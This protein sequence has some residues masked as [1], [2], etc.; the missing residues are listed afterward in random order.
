MLARFANGHETMTAW[1]ALLLAGLFEI[2]WAVGLK[3]SD[4]FTRLWPSLG[5]VVAIG[6]SFV[7]MSLS[8]K[9]IP[10][11]TAYAIWTGT[12]AAGAI[13]V[14]MVLFGESADAL[15]VVCLTLIVIGIVGLRLASS[16]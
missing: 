6:L 8:L 2:A 7:M 11:G 13:L 1:H 16:H 4:G 9:S 14:G 5:T 3:Y 10:F 12:G 15:R